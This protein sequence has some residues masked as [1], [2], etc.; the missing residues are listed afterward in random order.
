MFTFTLTLLLHFNKFYFNLSSLKYP[1]ITDSNTFRTSFPHHFQ[2]KFHIHSQENIFK[3]KHILQHV[4]NTLL[5]QSSKKKY[6]L[7]IHLAS[8]LSTKLPAHKMDASS[9]FDISRNHQNF[10]QTAYT[11]LKRSSY[12]H[13]FSNQT[14]I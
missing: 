14:I 3:L 5:L 13:R 10:N 1:P 8:T 4:K 7:S 6:F 12:L 2:K 11:P 9:V